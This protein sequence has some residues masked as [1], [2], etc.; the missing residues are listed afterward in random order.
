[1]QSPAIAKARQ[2]STNPSWESARDHEIHKVEYKYQGD[3]RPNTHAMSII[4]RNPD[5]K[6]D[7]EW[8]KNMVVDAVHTLDFPT[9]L[10][11]IHRALLTVIFPEKL[12]EMEP[13]QAAILTQFSGTEKATVRRMVEAHLKEEENW[14]AGRGGGSV[15]GRSKTRD[16]TP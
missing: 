15:E 10:L 9:S 1:M 13:M 12:R 14:N 2:N 7:Y 5:G 6:L 8:A 3:D 16:G 4:R 11:P